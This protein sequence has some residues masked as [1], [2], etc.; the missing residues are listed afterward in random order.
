M[1]WNPA[2]LSKYTFTE[3]KLKTR[4]P[5]MTECKNWKIKNQ[6]ETLK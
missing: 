4:N 2:S 3:N 6:P 5:K 1:T